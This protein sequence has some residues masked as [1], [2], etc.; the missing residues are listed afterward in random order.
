[1]GEACGTYEG[2]RTGEY[3]DLVRRAEGKRPFGRPRHRWIT[4]DWI[5]KKWDVE[6]WGWID[7]AQYRDWWQAL[8]NAA[9]NLRVA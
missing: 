3:W 2:N 8:V 7:L 5:F 1:M 9:M 6:T 4:L